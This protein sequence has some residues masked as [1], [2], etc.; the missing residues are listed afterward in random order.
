MDFRCQ[1][2]FISV[3]SNRLQFLPMAH[4]GSLIT[5]F[6]VHKLIFQMRHEKQKFL[7]GLKYVFR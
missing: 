5:R 2:V 4:F 1:V 3:E 7:I 6:H